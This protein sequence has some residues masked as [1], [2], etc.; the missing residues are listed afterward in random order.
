MST[1]ETTQPYSA[2][3]GGYDLVMAH[4]DYPAWA[5]YVLDLIADHIP[6]AESIL[7][8]GCGTGTLALE[9]QE[10]ADE[11]TP[12]PGGLYYLG[13]DASPA[14][15]EVARAK[16][17]R[18]GA[19][20]GNLRFQVGDFFDA[21]EGSADVVLLLYDGLN[22]LLDG[23]AVARLLDSIARALRPGGIA[24]VDQS[25]PANSL[26]NE[27]HFDDE[28]EF[29]DFRYER[30][31]RFDEDQRLHVTVFDI[32]VDG[33]RYVEEHVQRA[34]EAEEVRRLIEASS[35]EEVAAYDGFTL[36][37]ATE[38]TER[39]HWVLRRPDGG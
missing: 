2:L 24:I 5:E 9:V 11:I 8:L 31:S 6:E 37:P 25:T 38:R 10:R 29:G 28:G 26:A 27:E 23:R 7:E 1:P 16:A 36:R 14:M 30:R 33:V 21:P 39:I 4:V 19:D 12:D 22:Y 17:A 32:T 18:L 3:A 15:I 34:Y 13:T 20:P 35:L